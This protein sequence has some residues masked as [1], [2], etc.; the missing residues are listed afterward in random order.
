MMS[1]NKQ[2]ISNPKTNSLC[3]GQ[4]GKFLIIR[5]SS[6]GDIVLTTPVIRCLKLQVP[7]AE[8]HFLTKKTF[9]GILA[10]NPY[11]DKLIVMDSS[12]D[13]MM[14]QLQYED[15]DYI[16]DL[17]HNLRTLRIKK[18][19]KSAKS[20]SF[21]KLNIQKW[22]LTALKINRLPTIHIVDRYLATLRFFNVVND[23]KGLDFF[24]NDKERIK[25]NDLPI[26]HVFGFIGIVIGAA[27]DTKKLPIH[28]LQQLCKALNY[29]IVLLGGIED[30]QA[31]EEIASV[32]RI[33]VYNACGKYSLAESADLVQ[34]AKLI[35]THD[36]GLMHIAAAFKKPIISIWGNTVPEFGMGPYY[37]NEAVSHELSEVSHLGCRPCSK[38]G[39]NKCPKGHFKCM[40]LQDMEKIKHM[41]ESYL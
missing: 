9:S 41:V 6:I 39:Y 16:I 37:G 13:L 5:F 21:D 33:K 7:D 38:I 32:D 19:L 27:L 24:L 17:H 40:E 31:G 11:V 36:T 28:K 20:F 34:K 26:S 15:Y 4:G 35:V 25:K 18:A 22:L 3:K 23:G 30:S 8:V 10:N 29:P 2:E 14:H 1:N 12:W